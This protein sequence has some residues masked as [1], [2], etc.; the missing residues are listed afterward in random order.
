V[1]GGWSKLFINS[2]LAQFVGGKM[3]KKTFFFSVLLLIV[4]ALEDA[5]RFVAWG[6]IYRASVEP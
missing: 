2:L 1:F 4:L 5:Q 3:K 6:K